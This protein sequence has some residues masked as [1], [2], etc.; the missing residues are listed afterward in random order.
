M[1]DQYEAVFAR[2]DTNGDGQLTVEEVTAAIASMFSASEVNDLSGIVKALFTEYDTD[3]DG[4]LSVSEFVP[5]AK[6][7]PELGS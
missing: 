7:L 5:L 6:N 2:Y 1:A 3:G 4:L